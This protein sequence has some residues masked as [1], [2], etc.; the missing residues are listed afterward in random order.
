MAS[1][2]RVAPWVLV[3][4]DFRFTG[5]MDKANAHLARGLARHGAAVHLVAHSVE[6]GLAREAGVQVT[7][8]PRP[9]G[10]TVLG[11][12]LLDRAGRA[13]ARREQGRGAVVVTNGGNCLWPGV[14]W[15]HCVHDAWPCSDTG[16]PRWFRAKN[17]LAKRWARRRERLATGRARVVIT[18]SDKTRREV[19]ERLQ[20]PVDRV[21]VVYLGCDEGA[22]PADAATRARVRAE[23]GFAGDAPVLMFVG[24]LGWDDN[25]GFDRV[26]AA[27]RDLARE[28]AWTSRLLVVGDGARR[29]RWAEEAA[30][31]GCADR[32]RFVGV[33]D[34]VGELLAAVDLLV[35]PVRYE[36]Y[37][38]AVQEAI[39]RGV[40]AV[41]S[42][43]AGV[44]ERYPPAV[45]A[46]LLERPDA[47][48]C[49]TAAILRWSGA[50]EH[51]REAFDAFGA[52]L[53]RYT[54]TDMVDRIVAV[55]S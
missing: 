3:A 22:V 50:R 48:G 15:I 13:I 1:A 31:A 29:A 23:L 49:L 12:R 30:R 5:G 53:R 38:L 39:A 6:A 42:A 18:N 10:A 47:P 21:T 37:G 46:L 24:A 16:A 32:V 9:L 2:A 51:W 54:W 11:E 28:A 17:G 44:A 55:A 27:W 33:S 8:V 19:V 26:W 34:R 40:P 20:V 52:T 36:A 45:R 4:G 35:S 43:S 25:K 14:S 41:V 7:R